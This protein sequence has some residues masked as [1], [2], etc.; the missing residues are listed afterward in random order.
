MVTTERKATVDLEGNVD[1]PFISLTFTTT[2]WE[3]REEGVWRLV[4]W[5]CSQLFVLISDIRQI[6][7]KKKTQN[8]LLIPR[9]FNNSHGGYW[10]SERKELVNC[11]W[12]WPWRCRCRAGDSLCRNE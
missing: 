6:E 7:K 11:R 1:Q 4:C 9:R 3:V 8:R 12:Q 2:L 5:F 10:Q